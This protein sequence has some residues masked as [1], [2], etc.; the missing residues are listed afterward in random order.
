MH[1]CH[2]STHPVLF[3]LSPI[4]ET[5]NKITTK[6]ST[7]SS[8]PLSYVR[9]MADPRKHKLETKPQNRNCF[10]F[11]SPLLRETRNENHEILANKTERL[12][13][14]AKTGLFV[15]GTKF[16][17]VAVVSNQNETQVHASANRSSPR[18]DLYKVH[19]FQDLSL[20]RQIKKL[21]S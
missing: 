2:I 15:D 12:M 20:P 19:T 11:L 1:T 13:Q 18:N 4:L 16:A 7:L 14:T 6:L 9:V 21:K 5:S 3:E 8:K 17:P 10:F